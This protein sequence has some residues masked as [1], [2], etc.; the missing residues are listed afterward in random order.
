MLYVAYYEFKSILQ[1]LMSSGE[2]GFDVFAGATL[3]PGTSGT[4]AVL[5]KHAVGRTPVPRTRKAAF[6][7]AG[8]AVVTLYALVLP[9]LVSAMTGYASIYTPLLTDFYGAEE[10]TTQGKVFP[11]GAGLLPIYGLVEDA[12]RLYLEPSGN[13]TMVPDYDTDLQP[14]FYLPKYA[15]VNTRFDVMECKS[16]TTE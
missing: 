11:C 1:H 12:H 4:F 6:M 3:Q 9:T 2:V 16:S 13:G 7:Y 8:M 15:G 14:V 10:G 5:F